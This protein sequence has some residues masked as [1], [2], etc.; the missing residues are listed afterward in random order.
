MLEQQIK[1]SI[2]DY[3]SYLRRRD[4]LDFWFTHS[5]GQYDAKRRVWRSR[6]SKYDRLGIADISGVLKGGKAIFIEVKTKRGVQSEDQ[7]LFEQSCKLF[8]AIYILARSVKD[9]EDALR[10]HIGNGENYLS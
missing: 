2:G 9:V 6:N 3:L 5:V 7:K 1:H 4:V 10:G 8:G